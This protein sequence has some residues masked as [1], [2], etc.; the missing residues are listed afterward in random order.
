MSEEDEFV[1]AM[2]KLPRPVPCFANGGVCP[3]CG[4]LHGTITFGEN[5]CADCAR[6]F[7]FGYPDWHE[8]KDPISHVPFPWKQWDTFKRA[9]LMEDWAPTKLLEQ[10]YFQMSEEQLGLRANEMRPN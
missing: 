2:R 3:W 4:F 10:I 9:D 8:G 5:I 1:K 6:S 7:C